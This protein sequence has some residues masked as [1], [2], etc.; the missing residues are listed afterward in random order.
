MGAIAEIFRHYGDDYLAG[1]SGLPATHR[2]VVRAVQ[3]YRT[4]ENGSIVFGCCDCLRP[5]TVF[6]SCGNRH[7]PT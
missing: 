5:V 6:R 3:R 2:K 4:P 1:F 7:C